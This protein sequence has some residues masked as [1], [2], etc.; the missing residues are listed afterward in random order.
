MDCSLRLMDAARRRLVT[1]ETGAPRHGSSYEAVRLW[2]NRGRVPSGLDARAHA[3]S[4]MQEPPDDASVLDAE[5]ERAIPF[6]VPGASQFRTRET[7]ERLA[8]RSAD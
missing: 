7:S 2:Q 5:A 6:G 1:H 4:Q 3:T 8:R